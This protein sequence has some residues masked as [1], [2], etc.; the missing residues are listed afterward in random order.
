MVNI[1]KL[2]W[3]IPDKDRYDYISN[4]KNLSDD[5]IE[6]LI[7]PHFK[8]DCW[9]GCAFLLA[10]LDDKKIIPLLPQLLEW[11]MDLNWPGFA[12]IDKRI[13]KLPKEQI[14]P[15]LM[16]AFEKAKMTNDEEW[17]ENLSDSFL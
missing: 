11:Y 17:Y 14:R 10:T 4:V 2:S 8:Q 12:I 3:K 1:D 16:S 7:M 9:E 15:S 13:K 6:S 5:D